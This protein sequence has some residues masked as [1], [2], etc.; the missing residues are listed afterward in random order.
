MPRRHRLTLGEGGPGRVIHPR[1]VGG[2]LD[3]LGLLGS[4]LA[5]CVALL[6]RAP[7][8][9]SLGFAGRTRRVPQGCR[10]AGQPDRSKPAQRP[11]SPAPRSGVRCKPQLGMIVGLPIKIATQLT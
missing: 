9:R 10:S 8:S 5:W 2:V 7:F 6:A 3:D 4:G 1:Q 11:A